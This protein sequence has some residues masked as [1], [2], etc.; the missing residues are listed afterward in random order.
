[1]VYH[2]LLSLLLFSEILVPQRNHFQPQPSIIILTVTA[3]LAVKF[4]S[5]AYN[6][7]PDRTALFHP[8]IYCLHPGNTFK[9]PL[10]KHT[11]GIRFRQHLTPTECQFSFIS[12]APAPPV[13]TKRLTQVYAVKPALQSSGHALAALNVFQAVFPLQSR[14]QVYCLRSGNAVETERFAKTSLDLGKTPCLRLPVR[15]ST[16]LYAFKAIVPLRSLSRMNYL[17]LIN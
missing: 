16:S 3:S 2:T 9:T 17:H 11:F 8:Y 10:V 7:L 12:R 13:E 15:A 1:M 5:L 14:S 4:F 6:S